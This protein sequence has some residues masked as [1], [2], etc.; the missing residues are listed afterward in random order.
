MVITVVI[1]TYNRRQ[2]LANCLESLFRQTCDYGDLEII[3]VLD[4]STDGT[5]ESLGELKFPCATQFIEQPNHGQASARNAGIRAAKG[6]YILLID[7]DFVC[8]SALIDEH[9]KWH[10]SPGL[11]VFGPILRELGD[12][13]LPAIAVDREIRPFYEQHSAGF[14]PTAWLPPNSS[15]EK[16][17]LLACGAYDEQFSS[18]REDTELGMRLADH[19][20]S[21]QYAPKAL[22]HQRYRK[23][24]D[25]L[26]ADAE[27]FGKNDVR[28]LRKRPDYFR[29]CNLSQVDQGPAWK[30]VA[31]RFLAV[32]PLSLE[33]LFRLPYRVAEQ[34]ELKGTFREIGIRLLNLRRY[35]VWLRAAVKEADGWERLIFL[36]ETSRRK[37]SR[38]SG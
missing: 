35:I 23:T 20:I 37:N 22:V 34:L 36:I 8:D 29:F 12:R 33:P 3:V 4:G 9:L 7:D 38:T 15:A 21:F 19:G 18:A 16:E 1:P 5:I 11:V 17:V 6:K 24:A 27:L 31:R 32:A 2:S 13:T 30:R 10:S 28:L 26:I 25:D 14:R